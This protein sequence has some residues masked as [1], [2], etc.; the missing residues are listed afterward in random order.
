MWL[1]I[2]FALCI[3]ALDQG[4]KYWA[5]TTLTIGKP[6]PV[7]GEAL[8]WLLVKNSGAAFSFASNATWVF[9]LI[10]AAVAVLILLNLYR[11]RALVWSI[12]AGLVLGGT[13]GNLTDRLLR[14][15]SFGQGHVIDF[16]YTPWMMP[17]IYN[18]AD[19]AVVI[20]MCLFVLLT[21]LGID[22][23][24]KRKRTDAAQEQ[25]QEERSD[26][27]PDNGDDD[28]QPQNVVQSEE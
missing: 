27:T 28:S 19:I 25:A 8:Q 23:E 22:F 6:V 26:G 15:P 16:V 20:G 18:V 12:F 5:L 13:L 4:T 24:G 10:S 9:T 21:L 3:I 11:L 7:L 17:A 14:E 2:V 1:P